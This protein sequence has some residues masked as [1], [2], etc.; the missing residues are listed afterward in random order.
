MK[1]KATWHKFE[2]RKEPDFIT[3]SNGINNQRVS[4]LGFHLI[5][6]SY[7]FGK[8]Q[9]CNRILEIKAKVTTQYVG[10]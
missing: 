3:L 7:T 5:P 1:V 9:D 4:N 6:E 8:V 2:N 10:N